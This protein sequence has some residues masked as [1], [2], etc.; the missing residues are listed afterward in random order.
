MRSVLIVGASVAGVSAADALREAGFDGSIT[1]AGAEPHTPYD[2]PPLSKQALDIE[3]SR[4]GLYPLRGA[5]HYDEQQVELLLGKTA[6]ALDVQRRT[7][8]FSDGDV[9]LFDSLVIATGC[10]ANTLSTTSGEPL[11][12]LRTLDDARWLAK[13][14]AVNSR[15]VLIGAGFIGLEVAAGLR[16]RGL[17]V[18]VLESAPTPFQHSLGPELAD[19]LCGYHAAQGVRIIS[20]IQVAAVE[21]APGTYKVVLADGRVL[22]AGIVLAGIGVRPNTEWLQGSGVPCSDV[23]VLCDASGSTG[24]AGI[25]AAGDVAATHHAPSGR[26]MRIE[27]W[28]HA[29]EQGRA[30]ARHLLLGEQARLTPYFWTDQHSCKLQGYGRRQSGDSTRVVEGDLASGEFLALFGANEHFHG[31]IA[32]GRPRSLRGYRKLLEQ[33]SSWS[34]ALAMAEANATR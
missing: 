18:T 25:F 4:E 12:V 19:W 32:S 21:G 17:D 15:A 26:V 20:G 2:R 14:A 33:N 1:V 23:G 28:T 13:A 30:A 27:H 11:P 24:M 8:S 29:V 5:A 10:R 3:D 16:R 31:V 9:R 7:V 22:E 34:Q 6:S